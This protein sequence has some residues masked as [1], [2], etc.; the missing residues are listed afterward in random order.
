MDLVKPQDEFIALKL[1]TV[2]F[3]SDPETPPG[4]KVRSIH[5]LCDED[6]MKIAQLVEELARY[7]K[8]V[9]F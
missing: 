7:V 4:E 9:F 3:S 6:K 2:N 1:P 5:D 8:C